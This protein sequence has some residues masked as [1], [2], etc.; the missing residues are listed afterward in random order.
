ML[1]LWSALKYL[2]VVI[3]ILLFDIATSVILAVVSA[4]WCVGPPPDK[5]LALK[6]L[7]AAAVIALVLCI[8]G[9]T[10]LR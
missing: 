1:W 3:D 8:G 4:W 6:I 9:C 5:T 2:V 10:L 7:F